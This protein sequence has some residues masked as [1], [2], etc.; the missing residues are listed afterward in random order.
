MFPDC[1][2]FSGYQSSPVRHNTD[3]ISGFE[4]MSIAESP[5]VSAD[6]PLFK[7]DPPTAWAVDEISIPPVVFEPDPEPQYADQKQ[8]TEKPQPVAKGSRKPKLQ[9]RKK[10]YR[11]IFRPFESAESTEL[12][13]KLLRMCVD[14]RFTV[15]QVS[16]MDMLCT[17]AMGL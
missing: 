11:A 2:S 4:V 10:A 17:Y 1:D 8:V 13:V 5:K 12:T 14:K 9:R 7:N 3:S 6:F 15:E 16:G